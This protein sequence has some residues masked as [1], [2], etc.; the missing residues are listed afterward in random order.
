MREKI[1]AANTAESGDQVRLK[2]FLGMR[3]GVYLAIL[4]SFVL[5]AILFFLLLYPGIARPGSVVVFTSEPAGAALRID[6]VYAGSS[7]C[8]VFASKGAR[9]MEAVL[10]G[11]GGERVECDVK[12]RLFASRIFPR[13]HPLHITL[14][15]ADPAAALAMGAGDFAAWTFGGEP[16]PAWQVPM[17][18]SEG[19][20]RIGA[21]AAEEEA[22]G[23]I[24]ASARFAVTR[25]AL[26]DL[27][28]AKNLADAGG[29]PPSPLSIARTVRETAAWLSANDGSA[30]WLADTLPSDSAAALFS[31]AWYQ[32]QLAAFAGIT[33][34][35][36]LPPPPGEAG[37]AG[38][39]PSSQI[40]VGGLLFAE[41]G[42][43][44]LVQGEPF[45]HP[46]AIEPFLICATVVPAP[47]YEDFLD[48][49]PQWRP[50]QRDALVRQGLA[51]GEYLADFGRIAAGPNR[52][53]TGIS[54]ASWYAAEA[55][56]RWLSGR[57]P[58]SFSG[59]EIR[60]P[61]EAEWEFAAKAA[62]GWGGLGSV[63]EWC[64]DPYSPL[65]FL[66]APPGATAAV[67]SPQ[68][69]VRGSSWLNAAASAGV[70]TRASLPPESCSPF[71][72]FR[73]VIA[74]K[75]G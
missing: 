27:V 16:T 14:E 15:A 63:W 42:A 49:N 32:Q 22:A 10:P 8:S 57:L 38:G 6:G 69:S 60:L 50:D 2:P 65:P 23:I 70:E 62:R 28:R 18:L 64:A 31:S 12:G 44:V 39:A 40:R 13:R 29:L 55:Y 48:A 56:C 66:D 34:L 33:A 71:V 5:L 58:E 26:R 41:V 7:P 17:D 61:T 53:I 1:T 43:G 46:V 20:Y 59:W 68:R 9:I 30:A 45:P 25:A 67:G 4:Y 74:K 11:F 75:S 47:A 52:A 3:P 72:Y 35:E 51:T 37:S 19:V 73:P 54:A 21:A 36:A 24:A